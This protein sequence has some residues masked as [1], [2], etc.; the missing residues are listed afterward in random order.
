MDV[1]DT[2]T[3]TFTELQGYLQA[4]QQLREDIRFAVRDIEQTTREIQKVLQAIHQPQGLT[5]IALVCENSRKLFKDVQDQ[6]KILSDKIPANQYYKYHDHWKFAIQRLAF[7]AA[8][9]IF[10]ETEQLI[11]RQT[12]ADI[13]GVKVSKEDGFH[14]DLD[15]YLMGLLQLASELSRLAVNAVIAGDYARPLQISSF[16]GELESG[17]RLLNLK[18]D[19]LRKRFDALKYDVKKVEEVVY[20]LSIRGLKPSTET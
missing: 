20:D 1:S 10:L 2:L 13:I 16:L 12:A 19:A 7:L 6:I 17:F 4:E 14:V 8:L 5:K 11:D 3:A 15:D 9:V 18:N